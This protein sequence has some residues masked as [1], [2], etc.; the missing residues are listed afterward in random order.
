MA[1]TFDRVKQ[2]I[3][4]RLDVDESKVVMEASFKEDLEADSLDVVELVMELEDE[5][6]LEISDEEAEKINTVGDAVNYISSQS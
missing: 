5:F 6:D 4:D 3:V 2:I 1:D